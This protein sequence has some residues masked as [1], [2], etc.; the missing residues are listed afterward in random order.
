[1][2]KD[3]SCM[4]KFEIDSIREMQLRQASVSSVCQ[5][6]PLVGYRLFFD[7]SGNAVR[8]G[9][10][11]G[12]GLNLKPEDKFFVLGG[13]L[14][15]DKITTEELLQ[16]MGKTSGSELKSTSILRGDFPSVLGKENLHRLLKLIVD[17]GWSVHFLSVQALYFAIVDIVDSL[18][19]N[20]SPYKIDHYALKQALYNVVSSNLEAAIS[21][22]KKYKYP[23]IKK[24]DVK[25]FVEALCR[26]LRDNFRVEDVAEITILVGLLKAKQDA[27]E[28]LFLQGS[29]LEAH[30]WIA[31]Y[32]PFYWTRIIDFA[33][34]ELILDE[35]PKYRKS[36]DEM[37]LSY[38]GAPLNNWSMIDST[39]DPMIQV[40]DGI[41]SVV[42]KYCI[43]IDQDESAV[44]SAIES[45]SSYQALNFRLLN[46][47]L[48]RSASLNPLLHRYISC[49]DIVIRMRDCVS[50]FTISTE[51]ELKSALAAVSG[52]GNT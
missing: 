8:V 48:S 2:A 35:Q 23:R 4:K 9:I 41:S 36:L 24:K 7:E 13:V 32:S 12:A 28:L 51:A 38:H 3:E 52:L 27:E 5:C 49:S 22:L 31:D 30:E 1:M 44:R 21:L 39:A 47:I 14:A 15:K 50:S 25:P 19:W 46:Y 37:N 33:D 10:Q 16:A 45:F 34:N 17:K 43:F 20:E 26:F 18:D 42:R 11:N 40:S 6:T 29:E